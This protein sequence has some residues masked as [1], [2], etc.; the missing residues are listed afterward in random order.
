MEHRRRVI[1]K[2][3]KK[4]EDGRDLLKVIY[5]THPSLRSPSM[6]VTE[7]TASLFHIAVNSG[8][9]GRHCQISNIS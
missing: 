1:K 6:D 5:Q 7:Q 4:G 3:K 9:M 2:E 8:G